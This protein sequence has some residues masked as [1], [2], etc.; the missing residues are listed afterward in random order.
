MYCPGKRYYTDVGAARRGVR[1]AVRLAIRYGGEAHDPERASGAEHPLAQIDPAPFALVAGLTGT[2]VAFNGYAG[3][4]LP[5]DDQARM[6]L[7]IL[8]GPLRLPD[9]LSLIHI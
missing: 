8:R 3:L 9:D 5:G 6:P 1:R 4:A 2:G 7:E